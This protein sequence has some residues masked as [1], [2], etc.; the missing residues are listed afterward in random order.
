MKESINTTHPASLAMLKDAIEK[1]AARCTYGMNAENKPAKLEI[2]RLL[3]HG[4]TAQIFIGV[5]DEHPTTIAGLTLEQAEAIEW[6][7]CKLC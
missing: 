4:I 2:S 5:N 6:A 1:G 3:N 7:F